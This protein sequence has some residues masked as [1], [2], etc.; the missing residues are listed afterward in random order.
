MKKTNRKSATIR[1][2]NVIL[3]YDT[4]KRDSELEK[5]SI[6]FLADINKVLREAFPVEL[7]QFQ[8][9]FVGN[10]KMKIGVMPN[11]DEEV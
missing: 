4:K 10:K 6:E 2:F 5:Y 9:E 11:D 7:P 1:V 3:T 8:I